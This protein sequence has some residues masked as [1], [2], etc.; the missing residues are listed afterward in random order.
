MMLSIVLR[1]ILGPCCPE[2]VGTW[3]GVVVPC[4]IQQLIAAIQIE[5]GD[6][7]LVG[8]GGYSFQSVDGFCK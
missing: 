4:R 8:I 6:N 1:K 7:F 2:V 5:K 3:Y